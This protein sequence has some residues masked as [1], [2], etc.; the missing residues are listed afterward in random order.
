[1][2]A[3]Q[4]IPSASEHTAREQ[5]VSTVTGDRLC[6]TCSYNLVGQTVLRE[7]HYGL[8]IVRCPECG[9]VA[10]V[11]EYPLLGRWANRWGAVLAALYFIF[12]LGMWPASSG[13]IV[14]MAVGIA[15]EAAH[16]YGRYLNDLESAEEQAAA[17]SPGQP[18]PTPLPTVPTGR[19]ITRIITGLAGGDDFTKWWDQQDQ[20]AT[21]AQAGGWRGAVNWQALVLWLP[22]GLLAFLYGWFWSVAL[23][24]FR[25]RWTLLWGAMIIALALLFGI[26]PYLTW[27]GG[28]V[29]YYMDAARQQISPTIFCATVA[30]SVFPLLLGLLFGRP[31]TRSLVRALLPPALRGSLALL[32]T[33]E[34][35]QPPRGIHARR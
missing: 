24:Q 18:P 30:F 31:L 16:S 29:G 3:V 14:G 8:L 25:R 9:T 5:R 12:L 26:G 23:L 34:G 21:F 33:T 17:A 6:T 32:W 1:L 2:T 19:Q 28:E 22:A 11:Q 20:A 7:P 4:T 15:E 35:L 10:S 13:T 27:I